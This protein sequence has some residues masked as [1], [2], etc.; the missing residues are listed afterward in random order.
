M[1]SAVGGA[2]K[3]MPG[4]PANPWSMPSVARIRVSPRAT[5]SRDSS[6]EG[7]R[8]PTTPLRTRSCSGARAR[9][10]EHAVDIADA[11]PGEAA[12]REQPEAQDHAARVPQ[13]LVAAQES[14]AAARARDRPRARRWPS[15]PRSPL[16]VRDQVRR[17]R[18]PARRRPRS[19][20]RGTDRPTRSRASAWRR[21]HSTRGGRPSPPPTS[22][23]PLLDAD[24]G[25][26]ADRGRDLELVHEP[27]H[28]G[29]P[30]AHAPRCRVPVLQRLTDVRDAVTI[31]ARRDDEAAVLAVRRPRRRMISPRLAY[32]TMLRASSEIAVATMV[33]S[34]EENPSR[35]AS[36]RPCWRAATM[37]MS[38]ATGT[39]TSSAE[40]A[41]SP[42]PLGPGARLEEC[43]ALLEV[44]AGRHTLQVQAQAGPWRARRRGRCRRSPSPPRA[45]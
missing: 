29:Q 11:E 40:A 39:R 37:S 21:V 4:S 42:P 24:H 30:D 15:S 3:A 2:A 35:M 32:S 44:E 16:P 34:L 13:P 27:L 41:P 5:V 28:A 6:S 12:R 31:V 36:A 38:D 23:P 17:P 18:P 7:R 20:T 19:G 33:A 43:E 14:G 8:R 9:P 22:S 25:A 10:Q 26:L 45:A 1:R